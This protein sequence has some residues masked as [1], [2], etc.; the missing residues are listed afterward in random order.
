MMNKG[1]LQKFGPGGLSG[2]YIQGIFKWL[3]SVGLNLI[4]GSCCFGAAG[5]EV[6]GRVSLRPDGTVW[7]DR[8]GRD[9]IMENL[10]AGRGSPRRQRATGKSG[11]ALL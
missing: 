3:V 7:K 9:L 5:R 2:S 8:Q 4:D 1:G 6:P 11:E 10:L